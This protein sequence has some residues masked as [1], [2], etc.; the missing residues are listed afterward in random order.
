MKLNKKDSQ[1]DSKYFNSEKEIQNL[2]PKQKKTNHKL[3]N[4]SLQGNYKKPSKD[5]IQ[6]KFNS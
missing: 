1:K 2:K 4:K 6:R 5:G 3:Q